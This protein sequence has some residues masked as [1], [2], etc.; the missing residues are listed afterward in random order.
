MRMSSLLLNWKMLY[1]CK[2]ERCKGVVQYGVHTK[3]SPGTSTGKATCKT[4]VHY[5]KMADA[6]E[7]IGNTLVFN[8]I[9]I[10]QELQLL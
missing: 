4:D 9:A 10:A 3:H 6:P 8:T 7:S 5:G 2:H 1:V